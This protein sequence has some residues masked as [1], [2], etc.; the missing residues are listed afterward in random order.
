MTKQMGLNIGE[1][2]GPIPASE[3]STSDSLQRWGTMG[4]ECC[5]H[6]P[7]VL[8]TLF[9][10]KFVELFYYFCKKLL[11]GQSWGKWRSHIFCN[12]KT[13]GINK[14]EVLKSYLEKWEV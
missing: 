11:E 1:L 10:F 13:K 7:F 6:T 5:I 14:N 12:V 2:Y 8:L 3:K 4:G 9:F